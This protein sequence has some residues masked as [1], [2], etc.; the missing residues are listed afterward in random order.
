MSLSIVLDIRFATITINLVNK[1]STSFTYFITSLWNENIVSPF[2]SLPE[3][4]VHI[5]NWHRRY[6]VSFYIQAWVSEYNWNLDWRAIAS[7]TSVNY[8]NL[9]LW[10]IVAVWSMTTAWADAA[11]S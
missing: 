9:N 1:F 11:D 10:L 5:M 8:D 3:I 6:R 7:K 4:T 2:T